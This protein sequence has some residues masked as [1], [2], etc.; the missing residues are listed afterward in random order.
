M[1]PPLPILAEGDRWVIVAKPPG[2]VVHRSEWAPYAPAV[3]QTLRNQLGTRVYPVHRLDGAVSGCLLMATDPGVSGRLAAALQADNA[4]KRYLAF[5]RGHFAADGDVDI[6]KPMKDDNG[7]LRD[8]RSVVRCIGRSHDP[9]CSLLEVEPFTGRFH[10]VRRHVRDLNH[11]VLGDSDHGDNKEN[12]AWKA[13]GLARLGLHCLGLAFDA[14]EGG[15]VDVACP[16]SV[17]HVAVWSTLP[18][19]AEAVA[20]RPILGAA[21]LDYWGEGRVSADA[22]APAGVAGQ[23]PDG[24]RGIVGEEDA[25]AAGQEFFEE[26]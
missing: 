15:R 17:D 23:A 2:M 5:V 20:A 19:W 3:L 14:P 26:L 6:A 1:Y 25:A 4:C 16:P 22:V 24:H 21:P 10:Q 13:R 9:R 11:P 8:A 18:F 7:I 12:R